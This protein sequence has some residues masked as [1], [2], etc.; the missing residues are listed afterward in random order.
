MKRVVLAGALAAALVGFA[1]VAQPA[2]ASAAD[3]W[4]ATY[5][6]AGNTANDVGETS[7]TAA[8]APRVSA[9]WSAPLYS[10]SPFAP[11]VVNG[12]ALRVTSPTGIAAPSYLTSTSPVTGGTLST[13]PLPMDNAQYQWGLTVSGSRVLI[14]FSGFGRPGGIVAV[15]L[16]TRSV[17][18]TADLPAPA[19]SWSGNA[20]PSVAYTDGQR[21][22]VAGAGSPIVAY[23]VSDGA[24]LW[25]AP[26]TTTQGGS[27]GWGGMAVGN[28][29]VYTAGGQGLVAYDAT[30]GRPLWTGAGGQGR[31]V[32]AGG[33]VFAT[34]YGYAVAFPAGG[35][36]AATCSPLW[37]RTFSGIDTD[38]VVVGG[39]DASTIF[40]TYNKHGGAGGFVARLS[41]STGNVQW[42][43][44]TGRYAQGLVRGGDTVW[45]NSE[46]VDTDTTVRQ[47]IL[48]FSTTATGSTP[49]RTIPLQQDLAGFPQTLAIASGTL[50]QQL[51]ANLLMGYR[52]FATPQS[53]AAPVASF[54]TTVNGMSVLFDGR[55]STDREGHVYTYS[56]SSDEGYMNNTGQLT[57]TFQHAGTHR[58]TLTVTDG[59][60]ASGS[61]TQTVTV[62]GAPP[63]PSD[64]A[65]F[66]ADSFQRTASGGLG[67]ADVGGA[68]TALDGA[69][70]QSVSPGTARLA[71]T[72]AG[73]ST[74]A[75]LATV[76][77]ST[78]DMS[79]T[80]SL[81]AAPDGGGA[82]FYLIGRRTGVNQD[83]RLR[84]RFLGDGTVRLVLT[85]R[86]SSA[87]ET[88]LGA[89][90]VVAG[91]RYTPGTALHVRLQVTGTGTTTLRAR[92]WTGSTEPST[93][94]VTA[95]DTTPS[96][97]G[98][99]SVG[100]GAYLSGS[101][102][103]V[104]LTFSV[105]DF[106]DQQPG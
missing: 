72:A 46:Y 23:R 94:T 85:A 44:S 100:V 88:F 17:V 95:A 47:R 45:L 70:R 105:S 59:S 102:T 104:P 2:S 8:T 71:L 67:I 91:L 21:V 6:D 42:S 31:P 86:K 37:K 15:D 93:W 103:R 74:T 36:G 56:W 16:G 34:G 41:A 99:G 12:V 77:Q 90:T 61:T 43:A 22:Y 54:T 11:A 92:A 60:G 63:P 79:A 38:D 101:A 39:A 20:Q 1:V 98:A 89:E 87:S 66:A 52:V 24:L 40:V 50:F 9:A 96:L 82:S 3:T 5:G 55:Y 27:S 75:H 14:P 49:L 33:R 58:V 83:Y 25:R 13:I 78:A 28:G 32:V 51:N 57:W 19:V 97:Q 29:V 84:A 4:T 69:S 76:S 106:L 7:I 80:V 26:L 65:T 81:N 64:P 30:S 18:W 48:G 35:C 73:A 68:W 10:S 53:N 62:G